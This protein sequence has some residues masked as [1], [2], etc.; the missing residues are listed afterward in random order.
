MSYIT[1]PKY[2]ARPSPKTRTLSYR[3]T[4]QIHKSENQPWQNTTVKS[5]NPIPISTTVPTKSFLSGPGSSQSGV[6]PVFLHY[7]TFLV[8]TTEKVDQCICQGPQNADHGGISLDH[9]VIL[10]SARFPHH[11]ITIIPFEIGIYGDIFWGYANILFLN[12]S[13]ILV[14]INH[15]TN[16]HY[17]D[18]YQILV[19]YFH[20]SSYIY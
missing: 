12:H 15:L 4:N 20:C 19:F 17:Y 11:N 18:G 7:Q 14:S 8:A 16:N 5:T 9:L 6:C 13:P 3:T 2:S 1:I 10:V